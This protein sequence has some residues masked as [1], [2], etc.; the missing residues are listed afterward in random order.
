MLTV[1]G[2]CKMQMLCSLQDTAGEQV[3]HHHCS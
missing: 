1:V 2:A 3:D